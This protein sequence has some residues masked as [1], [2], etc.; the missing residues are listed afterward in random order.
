MAGL[1]WTMGIGMGGIKTGLIQYDR[2]TNGA[3]G[4]SLILPLLWLVTVA[5]YL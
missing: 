1:G 5:T 2:R 4:A 3:L